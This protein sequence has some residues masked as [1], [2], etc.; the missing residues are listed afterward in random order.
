MSVT[1]SIYW[2]HVIF[3]L[4]IYDLRCPIMQVSLKFSKV[5]PH[6]G[7]D[8]K[9]YVCLLLSLASPIWNKVKSKDSF[10][11]WDFYKD[12]RFVF[13]LLNCYDKNERLHLYFMTNDLCLKD[14]N[15]W[16][17]FLSKWIFRHILLA[18]AIFFL[19]KW[20]LIKGHLGCLS[21]RWQ[22]WKLISLPNII[23]HTFYI[24]FFPSQLFTNL[25][26]IPAVL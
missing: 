10:T 9:V 5:K 14:N 3:T 21:L 11:G 25:A 7:S 2:E 16:K 8:W 26:W 13:K 12:S 15:F 6:T 17:Y 19:K 24:A 22:F 18:K 4:A 20:T 23:V 1:C